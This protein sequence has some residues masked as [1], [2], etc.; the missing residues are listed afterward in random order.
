MTLLANNAMAYDF[1]T[2]CSTG[3]TLYYNIT[4][5]VEPYTVEVTSENTE[6]PYYTTY[7][8]GELVIPETVEYNS[9]TY[10]VTS[11]GRT[12]FYECISLTEVTIPSSVTSIG[13]NA[14][15]GCSSLTSVTI[16]NSVTSIGWDAFTNTGWYDNQSEGIIYL[17]N[18]CLGYKGNTPTSEIIFA[19]GTLG[20][21]DNAFS[22]YMAITSVTIP[23][24]VTSIGTNAFVSCIGLTSIT[25]P[26]SVTSIGAGA[27]YNCTGI[28]T[29]N[30][31]ATNCTTMGSSD[32]PVFNNC[33]SLS[34][35]NIGENVTNIPD[36][37]FYGCSGITSVTIPDGVESIG[38]EAFYI[39]S[40]LT[41]ITLGT[42]VMHI[43]SNAFKSTG[44]YSNQS[45]GIIYLD[46]WCL[47]YKGNT[48]TSEIIFA[49]GTLGIADNAFYDCTYLPSVTIPE[50]V[51]SIG[52][53]AFFSCDGLTSINFNA[54]NC[55]SMEKPF[56]SC[57]ALSTL[58]IGENVTI[59]PDYAFMESNC[60]QLTTL[61]IPNSVTRIGA[62]AFSGFNGLTTVNFN[63]TNCVTMGHMIGQDDDYNYPVF[64]DCYVFSTLN[65]GESVTNIPDDAFS[66]NGGL[67]GTLTIPNS[68]TNIGNSAFR[69]CGGF[70][71][72][73]ISE[74]VTSI[75]AWA[76]SDCSGLTSITIP[77]SVE[78]VGELAF[79]G[80]SGLDTVNFN[81]T[82]CTTMGNGDRSVFF[83]CTLAELN[84]GENVTNIPENTFYRTNITNINAYSYTPPTVASSSFGTEVYSSANVYTP[85]EAAEIYRNDNV[86]GQFTNIYGDTTVNFSIT[87]QT[88][89]ET[90]GS[91]TGAGT[92]TCEDEAIL[93][94]TPNE[95]YRFLQWNDGNTD[96][97][98]TVVVTADST[99]TAGFKVVYTVTVQS[100]NEAYGTVSG[101]GTYDE[102]STATISA[103]PYQ[104][105][106]FVRWDDDNADNPRTI[107]VTDDVTFTA[108]F[109]ELPSYTITVLSSDEAYGSVS[110][111]GTYY[112]GS[113]ATISATPYQGYRFVRWDDD[114]ADNPR[115]ITVTDDVTFTAI[116]EE[117][118]S[119]TITVLSSD[120]AYGSVS[121]GGTY[122]EGSTATISATPYQGYRFVSWNDGDES[123]PRTIVVTSDSTFIAD[124]VKCEITQTIDTV[125][126]N[127]VTVGDHTFYSTGNYSFAVLHETACDTIFDIHLR[128]LAE[129]V[130]D[131]G[132]NPTKSLLNINS[133][134]FV[135]AV[136]F[137]SVTGQLVMRK[138]VNGYEAEFDVE[139]LEDGVYILRI[140]SEESSLPSVYKVVKE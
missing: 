108:I 104:G 15:N 126:P 55:V 37:A 64:S 49:D 94:A 24:S 140:Y 90:M 31:N 17:N 120:E 136:E 68:V 74:S 92:F 41:D 33:T 93:T 2:V 132:P 106:R 116:F 91:V 54:T 10:S 6:E 129:P 46:N 89:N 5:Y 22:D 61:T 67:T 137:Y 56:A 134:G 25:I 135:S 69:S 131:I 82:N 40:D 9:I 84:I 11:I 62:W 60:S 26:E 95:G 23:N 85:C 100:N 4:S 53:R 44:W 98:R 3:Q 138:E 86:W 38:D 81:A 107:T 71:N 16:G 97:P 133:D 102:G 119:Y 12:A 78:S 76:F 35:L 14:F 139:G 28:T 70:T 1:S 34:T 45:N 101:G 77:E 59:I 113:T 51:I 50:S 73:T 66:G 58:N 30:F 19:D 103:T 110:G 109:E 79:Y 112:E 87:V 114:N 52:A 63:A 36:H 72:I 20:I 48:P 13:E 99:F 121:G 88:E 80:C 32:N 29:I 47:G 105:Y 125:V 42:G 83:S 123:S 130:Y 128:V 96:N 75:G 8:E 18:W 43:G 118:P 27:F 127:F 124:F 39:A 57:V 7:P 21:A 111:G 65:I 117:L 115:T 122:Y